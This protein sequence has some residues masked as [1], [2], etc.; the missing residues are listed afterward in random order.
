MEEPGN[1]VPRNK[2]RLTETFRLKLR[3]FVLNLDV[4]EES[5]YFV[6]VHPGLCRIISLILPGNCSKFFQ[7][8]TFDFFKLF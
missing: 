5:C 7:E 4:C 1:L 6:M 2:M 3:Y 8:T